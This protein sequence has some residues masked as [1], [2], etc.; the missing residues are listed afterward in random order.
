[1]KTLAALV[2]PLIFVGCVDGQDAAL[3][4]A[5]A[6]ENGSA[7][8]CEP[9][10]AAA[11]DA[12]NVAFKFY[13]AERKLDFAIPVAW[14]TTTEVTPLDPPQDPPTINLR[15]LSLEGR[16]F[17]GQISWR[18]DTSEGPTTFAIRLST[19]G[20]KTL[21]AIWSCKPT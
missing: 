16:S 11:R 7:S 3:L 10:N 21:W 6:A 14:K 17:T 20:D 15:W 12:G 9:V 5:P 2:S 1:M 13:A 4:L 8:F 18:D 19:N